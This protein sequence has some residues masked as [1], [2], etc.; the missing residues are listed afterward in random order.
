M[1][2]GHDMNTTF[3][4]I[5]SFSSFVINKTKYNYVELPWPSGYELRLALGRLRVLIPVKVIGG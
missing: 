4:A 5:L 2:A 1:L 3:N